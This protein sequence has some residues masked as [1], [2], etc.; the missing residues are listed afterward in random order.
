MALLAR[1][2]SANCDR[3]ASSTN[4]SEPRQSG[5]LGEEEE[6]EGQ[7]EEESRCR[8]T[9]D[10]DAEREEGVLSRGQGTAR[11]SSP[12]AGVCVQE[13]RWGD[14]AQLAGALAKFGGF[15]PDVVL[16]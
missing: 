7:E 13:L 9:A 15:G 11:R 8:P 3:T 12:V 5:G 16:A 14:G 4:R 10:G 2:V 6:E 1:N